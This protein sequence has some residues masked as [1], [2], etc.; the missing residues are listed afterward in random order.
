MLGPVEV[1]GVLEASLDDVI[2]KK[3]VYVSEKFAE[4]NPLFFDLHS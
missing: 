2:S 4:S 1:L 3:R